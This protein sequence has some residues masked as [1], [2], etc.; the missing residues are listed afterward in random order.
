MRFVVCG[1]VGNDEVRQ[2]REG[3]DAVV[4]ALG[5]AMALARRGVETE[6]VARLGD[7]PL[8]VDLLGVLERAGIGS[9]WCPRFEGPTCEAMLAWR[10]P[11]PPRL[12]EDDW[13]HVSG[14]VA[15][16]E[17]GH[18]ALMT[19]LATT[20]ATISCDLCLDHLGAAPESLLAEL[21]RLL[22][23]VGEAGGIVMVHHRDLAALGVLEDE[24]D[25]PET[26]RELAH[27]WAEA[28]G[29][30]MVVVHFD[31]WVEAVKPDGRVEIQQ[32]HA[33]SGAGLDGN[34]V[35]GFLHRYVHDPMALDRALLAVG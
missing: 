15:L 34:F 11:E 12:T 27:S 17:P 14:P 22:Q 1:A 20:R 4:G 3:S 29:L 9:G 31:T 19:R 24:E 8:A 26:L 6:F 7:D 35:A 5:V 33:P 10:R 16:G 30:A 28:Y 13:L 23:V 25:L 18:S 2:A 32:D 21:D